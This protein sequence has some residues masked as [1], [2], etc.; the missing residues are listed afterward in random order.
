MLGDT[1]ANQRLWQRR[2]V[3]CLFD[4]LRQAENDSLPILRWEIGAAGARLVGC[5]PEHDAPAHYHF[6]AWVLALHA[7]RSDPTR[8]GGQVH[9]TASA[10]I[11]DLV[12]VTLLADVDLPE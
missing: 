6:A 12:N 9:L 4:L 10:R 2:A 11:G 8:S 3:L 7:E 5:V 1:E